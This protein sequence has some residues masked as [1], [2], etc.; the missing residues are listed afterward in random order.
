LNRRELLT[1][2]AALL[3]HPLPPMPAPFTVNCRGRVGGFIAGRALVQG[4]WVTVRQMPDGR[5]VAEPSLK[6]L[7][8]RGTITV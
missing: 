6:N 4:E 5:L 2:A 8:I 3:L 1:G 7:V